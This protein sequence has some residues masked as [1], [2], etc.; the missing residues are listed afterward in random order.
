MLADPRSS[1]RWSPTSPRSGSTC[2]TSRPSCPTRCCS[3][4][5]TRRCARRMRRETE[6]FVD[7]VFRENRSVLDLLTANYT[8]LNERLAKHYGIPNVRGSHFRRVTLPDGQRAR[9]PA[10]AGQHPD[11]HVV[12]HAH[13]AGA[14]RQV[15]AREPAVGGAAAAAARH[16]GARRPKGAEPGKPLTMRE[17]MTRH[18]AN[19]ACASCHARMDPIGFAMENFDAVGRWRDTDGGQPHRRLGRVSGRHEVRRRGRAEAGAAAPSRAVRAAP[20]PSGCSCMPSAGT[21]NTMTRRRCA[22]SSATPRPAV[23]AG[24]AGAGR[25]EEPAVPDAGGGGS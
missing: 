13:L 23:H 2:A 20:W 25:R 3:R 10:R 18:R 7:S 1:D 6:L 21:C 5:S 4:T 11:D 14:A 24:V 19:P 16:P 9:R 22:R 17:A 12:R 15:G 8:F